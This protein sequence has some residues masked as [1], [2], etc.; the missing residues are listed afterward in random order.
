[1]RPMTEYTERTIQ[2]VREIAMAVARED[3]DLEGDIQGEL[4]YLLGKCVESHSRAASQELWHV[5]HN[6]RAGFEDMADARM[7]SGP[8]DYIDPFIQELIEDGGEG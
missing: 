5:L 4:T 8:H 3:P 1:M 7:A 2:G 6:L